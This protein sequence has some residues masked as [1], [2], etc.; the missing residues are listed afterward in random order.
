M[1][2]SEKELF[3]FMEKEGVKDEKKVALLTGMVVSIL[4]RSFSQCEKKREIEHLLTGLFVRLQEDFVGSVCE[5]DKRGLK[6]ESF[7]EVLNGIRN[8]LQC[9]SL[10]VTS[11]IEGAKRDRL[12]VEELLGLNA[13]DDNG[14]FCKEMWTEKESSSN[15]NAG[16][17]K[18]LTMQKRGFFDVPLFSA[19]TPGYLEQYVLCCKKKSE[20]L[21]VGQNFVQLVPSYS[22]LG[23]FYG[24]LP[25][26]MYYDGFRK[27][28]Y[29]VTNR[30]KGN[31]ASVVA[32]MKSDALEGSAKSKKKV[33]DCLAKH[34]V[35]SLHAGRCGPPEFLEDGMRT[36]YQVLHGSSC[37]AAKF[38]QLQISR[39]GKLSMGDFLASKDK[40][41]SRMFTNARGKGPGS[42]G[43]YKPIRTADKK[44]NNYFC[45]ESLMRSVWEN[46]HCQ[47]DARLMKSI[48]DLNGAGART[49]WTPESMKNMTDKEKD[50]S[51]TICG[52]V[53]N[54]WQ[55]FPRT[56]FILF[57]SAGETLK[58]WYPLDAVVG[59]KKPKAHNRL[60]SFVGYK[61]NRQMMEFVHDNG[62]WLCLDK[63]T[64][65]YFPLLSQVCSKRFHEKMPFYVTPSGSF[66]NVHMPLVILLCLVKEGIVVMRTEGYD[67]LSDM[68]K[69]KGTA[70]SELEFLMH[71]L[72]E[73][74]EGNDGNNE[75]FLRGMIES[76]I[77]SCDLLKKLVPSF[78]FNLDNAR[79]QEAFIRELGHRNREKSG[80]NC[81]ESALF[82]RLD[83]GVEESLE[84]VPLVEDCADVQ[85]YGLQCIG[86][87]L[88][89]NENAPDLK[90]MLNLICRGCVD[91]SCKD[92]PEYWSLVSLMSRYF[93]HSFP[94]VEEESKVYTDEERFVLYAHLL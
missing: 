63:T 65:E 1:V 77:E 39:E 78:S 56:L 48:F 91:S 14:S 68:G 55:V 57:H 53:T 51:T 64:K 54:I 83:H 89:L 75:E 80:D 10:M 44:M 79:L 33:K 36:L 24:R 46:V 4:S 94:N 18:F 52:T 86:E 59:T 12:A 25:P 72:V 6:I 60:L 66:V 88:V 20:M 11:S 69:K 92:K 50:Q 62:I 26:R 19:A 70:Y 90:G 61:L 58:N 16:R 45:L 38:L 76:G 42:K 85:K 73:E 47:D 3:E 29:D 15:L 34:V 49:V 84:E 93:D 9:C 31:A 2:D 37:S 67:M 13:Y 8:V 23:D 40:L 74:V 5:G 41:M 87:L 71:G 17:L 7:V 22:K 82:R 27:L 30:T 28:V 21:T 32:I 81:G 35:N 43:S